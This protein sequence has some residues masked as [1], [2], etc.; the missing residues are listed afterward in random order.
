MDVRGL[1]IGAAALAPSLA[2]CPLPALAQTGQ[3][4][5]V[6]IQGQADRMSDWYSAEGDHVIV[7]SNGNKA[8]LAR[9]T[10]NLERLHFLLS[11][12]LNRVGQP[13]DALKLR[14]TLVGDAAEFDDMNLRNI[15]SQQGPF[16]RAFPVQRYY[17]PRE[18]GAV[19]AVSRTD[20]AIEIERSVKLDIASLG[21]LQMNP[22]TGQLENSMF[23][24]G[25]PQQ[26]QDAST[27][28][29]IVPLPAEG[30]LYGAYAQ[31]YLLTY[32]PAAYP[33]W[34]LD[35]MGE[36]F[37]TMSIRPDGSI[38]YGKMPDGYRKVM[39]EFPT[40]QVADII[41]GRYLTQ[42]KTK[43]NPFHAWILTHYLFF[44]DARR[45]QL[46]RYLASIGRGG[47]M[48]AAASVF[49]DLGK[50]QS[51]VKA[52]DNSKLIFERMT[53]PPERAGEPAVTQLT[54]RQA[55]FLKGRIE[56]GS[57]IEIPPAP[58]PGTD[59][60]RAAQMTAARNNAIAA[61]DR[62]LVRLRSSAA[63]N[64]ASLEAQLLLAEAE[65]RTG[66]NNGCLAAAEAGLR[67]AQADSRALAWK[68]IAQAQIA[69]AGPTSERTARLRE[70]R[71]TIIQAN[72]ADTEGSLPLLA[73]YRSF[74]EAGEPATK[75]AAEGLLK[76][77]QNVPAAP[78]PRVL[79]G[80][81]FARTGHRDAAID[82][83][84]PVANGG[85]DSPERPRAE[86]VLKGSSK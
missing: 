18:D 27:A 32:L 69:I 78:G 60:E 46:S 36:L 29:N 41:T 48:E 83:V 14:I 23:G 33:R 73:Y 86:A 5:E 28:G 16:A 66:N 76:S 53:Y 25:A 75:A 22:Q 74:A 47:S 26:S 4:Q 8:A 80:E 19:M 40:V 67:A 12:L 55:S 65:C 37:S 21:V 52:Y 17:D 62:W 64:P 58:P 31:H 57:R 50:L 68:G 9:V 72:R 79:L 63:S 81:E 24:T 56:L 54:Q 43:W 59:A 42:P 39:E 34:Y 49:G 30:R 35:G 13:D 1:L 51:E 11:V 70:A 15:R 10:H 6:L 3:P 7:Y 77:V 84:M 71:A 2:L 45:S 38:D 85:Y 20:Q 61:R 82:A 44:N